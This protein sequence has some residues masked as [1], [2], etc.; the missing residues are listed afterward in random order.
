MLRSVASSLRRSAAAVSDV[1]TLRQGLYNIPAHSPEYAL[2]LRDTATSQGRASSSGNDGV[3]KSNG[4]ERDQG[5]TGNVEPNIVA[6]SL[7]VD[8]LQ[9]MKKFEVGCL[10]CIYSHPSLLSLLAS[11]L[12]EPM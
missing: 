7:L 1:H 12:R 11:P 8:T 9:L 4:Q 10:S 5:S 6:A 2:D 3:G